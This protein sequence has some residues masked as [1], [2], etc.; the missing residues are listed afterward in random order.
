[1]FDVVNFSLQM[2]IL[3]TT[4]LL[5]I[6]M[7]SIYYHS[8][9]SNTNTD[10]ISSIFSPLIYRVKSL[11]LKSNLASLAE[12]LGECYQLF[13]HCESSSY[14]LTSYGGIIGAKLLQ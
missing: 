4:I 1:M 5:A 7:I 2:F 10:T 3:K 12:G 6:G 8:L 14:S 9:T 11:E 13:L